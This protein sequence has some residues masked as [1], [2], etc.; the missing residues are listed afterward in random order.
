MNN[1]GLT[2]LANYQTKERMVVFIN[3]K[4][5]NILE[6]VNAKYGG[7]WVKVNELRLGDV[8]RFESEDDYLGFDNREDY[9]YCKGRLEI[10]A[11]KPR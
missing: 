3:P 9:N 5:N 4:E 2:I 10:K 8:L 1:T 6:I 7:S 11:I